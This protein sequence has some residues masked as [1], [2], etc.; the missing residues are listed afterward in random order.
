MTY[1]PWTSG[2]REPSFEETPFESIVHGFWF[3]IVTIT[4]VGYG[5]MIP[6]TPAGKAVGTMMILGGVIV[7][8]MPIGVVG[9]NFSRERLGAG[10]LGAVS[11]C[12][13]ALKVMKELGSWAKSA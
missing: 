6:K 4:T 5:D 2:T 9:A 11:S 3:V 12:G 7:L 10:V 1:R 13:G 8:A